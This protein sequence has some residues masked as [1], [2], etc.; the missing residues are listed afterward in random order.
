MMSN[1]NNNMKKLKQEKNSP[2]AVS[3]YVLSMKKQIEEEFESKYSKRINYLVGANNELAHDLKTCEEQCT[4]LARITDNIV[5]DDGGGGSRGK[6]YSD[7]RGGI[8][9]QQQ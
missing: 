6:I 1:N 9:Q 2:L 5:L 4:K 3:L 8:Y 7:G